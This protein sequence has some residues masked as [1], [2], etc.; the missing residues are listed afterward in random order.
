MIEVFEK[1]VIEITKQKMNAVFEKLKKDKLIQQKFRELADINSR[2]ERIHL[3]IKEN[4]NMEEDTL[5]WIDRRNE[6][7]IKRN[8][9]NLQLG[10]EG[11]EQ[12]WIE[13]IFH[14]EMENLKKVM[15]DARTTA[16]MKS[17]GTT[18][19]DDID[20]FDNRWELVEQY[21]KESKAIFIKGKKSEI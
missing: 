11:F 1:Q 4:S 2:L 17:F 21:I 7:S 20:I 9:V 15:D 14:F 3:I 12:A 18:I 6:L 19:I 8:K 10:E 16:Y 13:T 5:E